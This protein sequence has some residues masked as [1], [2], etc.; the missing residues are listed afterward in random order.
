VLVALRYSK[1]MTEVEALRKLNELVTD[2]AD[3][4]SVSE[5]RL[6]DFRQRLE[7]VPAAEGLLALASGA[8]CSA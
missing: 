7:A 6:E 1:S 4:L 2:I 3:A 5:K 8:C